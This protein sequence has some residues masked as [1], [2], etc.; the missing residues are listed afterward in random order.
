MINFVL[1][2]GL[3]FLIAGLV[4]LNHVRGID[5]RL[6]AAPAP[7]A[8][9]LMPFVHVVSVPPNPTRW[10]DRGGLPTVVADVN[11][12]DAV[13]ACATTVTAHDANRLQVTLAIDGVVVLSAALQ[14]VLAM[15]V[16]LAYSCPKEAKV[17]LSI[18]GE[19]TEP[20]S[21]IHVWF[22]GR[23]QPVLP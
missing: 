13:Y 18:R 15:P 8:N 5:R 4:L 21:A 17:Q 20:G 1:G 19:R 23:R 12:I 6:R 9:P 16:T 7:P 11:Y 3:M 22:I 10:G 14:V 2:F